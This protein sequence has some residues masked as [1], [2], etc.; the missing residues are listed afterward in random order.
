MKYKL[1]SLFTR[2]IKNFFQGLIVIAPIGIT[3][4]VVVSIFQNLDN[5]LPNM[6]K[7]I[8]PHLLERD[9]SGKTKLLPGI[10]F[11]ISFLLVVI[12]GWLSSIFIIEKYMS[13]IDHLLEKTPGVKIIYTTVKDLLEAFTGDKKKFNKPVL[14]NIDNQDVWRVGF[15]TRT[16]NN[17]FEMPEFCTVY[18]PHSYAISGITYL[19]KKDRI[20]ELPDSI[21]PA[22]AMKYILSGGLTDIEE[23]K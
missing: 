16:T 12:V 10:G 15:I 22:D 5:F 21:S 14:V 17:Q 2:L 23:T 1:N 9:E 19:V 4:W 18:V 20:K 7:D 8:A 13:F 6:L 11:L 3:V